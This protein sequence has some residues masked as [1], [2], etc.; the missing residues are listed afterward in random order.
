MQTLV[1]DKKK[2]RLIKEE[3][4]LKMKEDLK[5]IRLILKR[6]SEKGTEAREFFANLEKRKK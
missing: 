6:K 4:Y 3:E 1:I 5:D 2:Y